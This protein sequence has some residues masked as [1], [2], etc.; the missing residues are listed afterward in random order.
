MAAK[1]WRNMVVTM[2]QHPV[3]W[4]LTDLRSNVGALS[5]SR[6]VKNTTAMYLFNI[7]PLKGFLNVW[8]WRVSPARMAH[9]LFGFEVTET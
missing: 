6:P 1:C 7:S 2:P 9:E 3:L 8:S 4:A 5:R